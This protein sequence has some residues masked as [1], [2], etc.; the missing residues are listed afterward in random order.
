MNLLLGARHV[1]AT[2]LQIL[3][4]IDAQV[5][6]VYRQS[7][8]LANRKIHQSNNSTF[9]KWIPGI[10]AWDIRLVTIVFV[11]SPLSLSMFGL[12]ME[13]AFITVLVSNASSTMIFFLKKEKHQAAFDRSVHDLG[14]HIIIVTREQ[15]RINRG[16]RNEVKCWETTSK[17]S[18]SHLSLLFLSLN[19]LQVDRLSN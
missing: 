16:Q 17:V 11:S 15:S 4:L 13:A 19:T 18:P 3:L 12:Y 8:R 2:L 1:F 14:I 6:S 7:T 9:L 10:K 5:Q